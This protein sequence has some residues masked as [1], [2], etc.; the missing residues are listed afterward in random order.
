M[1]E[2]KRY[3]KFI[4][5]IF[6]L[7]FTIN[8]IVG[9]S[10]PMYIGN[11]VVTNKVIKFIYYGLFGG[12][13]TSAF[14]L[15]IISLIKRLLSANVQKRIVMLLLLP[16]WLCEEFCRC[17]IFLIPII[18]TQIKEYV[19]LHN[20]KEISDDI[21]IK[22]KPAYRNILIGLVI[23]VVQIIC[24][25]KLGDKNMYVLLFYRIVMII[26]NIYLW[27]NI[28]LDCRSILMEK[29]GC[30][31]R[32]FG[33]KRKYTWEEVVVK[34]L[35]YG[36]RNLNGS[37]PK[38]GVFFSIKPVEKDI[39]KDPRKFGLY[40]NP[41]NYFHVYLKTGKVYSF[42]NKMC[43]DREMFFKKISQWGVQLTVK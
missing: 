34:R 5:I 38:G 3:L 37:I 11:N 16:I 6:L 22:V 29:E 24:Y 39:E 32:L 21:C 10:K 18:L 2:L 36:Y 25:I 4:L 17:G 33:I 1:L 7:G 9:L 30:T 28:I 40:K 42:H 26:W 8:A 23:I 15:S 35:E 41:F 43:V 12:Y 13:M 27:A 14:A 31:I 19:E 20:T